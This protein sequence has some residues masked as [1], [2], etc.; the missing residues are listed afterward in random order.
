[1]MRLLIVF[2]CMASLTASA[3]PDLTGTYYCP[4]EDS[5]FNVL[6]QITQQTDSEGHVQYQRTQN[7]KSE[8]LVANGLED[9]AETDIFKGKIKYWCEGSILKT[10][11]TGDLY[12]DGELIGKLSSVMGYTLDQEKNLVSQGEANIIYAGE[13]YLINMDYKCLRK[14]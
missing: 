3:C 8:F 11:Q 1:M 6:V 10:A 5:E 12:E 4:D 13:S 2:I 7:K 9:S 14:N